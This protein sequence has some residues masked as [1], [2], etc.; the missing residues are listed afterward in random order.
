M[1]EAQKT[2]AQEWRAHWPLVMAATFGLS[3]GAM[4]TATLGL[5]MQPLNAEFGWSR[6]EMALGMTIFALITT[7]L[8]PFAGALVD[9]Y[10]ARAVGMPAI[11]LTGLMFAA[12]AMMSGALWT[13][14]LV[15]VLYSLASLGIRSPVWNSAVSAS[16]S[17]SRGFAIAI[18]LSGM[19]V[20]QML[21]PIITHWLVE[22]YGWRTAYA[23]LGI[24]WGG[25]GFLLVLLFFHDAR[26][27]RRIKQASASGSESETVRE[28]PGGLTLGQAVRDPRIL[29]ITFAIFV[30]SLIGAAVAVHLVPLLGTTGLTR[31]QAAGI[32]GVLGAGS[33]C[34]KLLAGWLVDRFNFKILPP[35]VFALPGA[36]YLLLLLLGPGSVAFSSLAIFFVG[37]GGG[38]GLQMTIYL[39]TRYAG[40]AHFGKIFGTIS[41]LMG[42]A[43]GIGP[44]VGGIVFDTTGS[45]TILMLVAIPAA[46]IAGI[47]VAGLGPFPHF[48]PIPIDAINRQSTPEAT[49]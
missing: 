15:W 17:A 22:D 34:G 8:T 36:G 45:Y 31:G 1:A 35:L 6:S 37:A 33:F 12:F 38:A 39:T 25:I 9:R 2:G 26:S 18:V 42:L 43:G 40:L 7:P 14:F 30:Q 11:G 13:W 44:L 47:A 48:A 23:G 19:A 27:R 4:P 20:T 41:S 49:K 29:R 16:F 3:F 46:F 24:G 10:G 21:A 28:I 32:A 5:F